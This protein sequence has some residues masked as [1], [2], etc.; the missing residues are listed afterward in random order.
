MLRT[1]QELKWNGPR[2]ADQTI[3]CADCGSIVIEVR[4]GCLQLVNSHHGYRHLNTVRVS[5]LTNRRPS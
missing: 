3:R 5:P 4:D 1:I 2:L